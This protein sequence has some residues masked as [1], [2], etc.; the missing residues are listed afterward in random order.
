MKKQYLFLFCVFSLL[1]PSSIFAFTVDA[2]EDKDVFVGATTVLGGSP[3]A[4]G[5]KEPYSYIWIDNNGM[6]ISNE[7]NPL[8]EVTFEGV[9]D[10]FVEVTDGSG[11][12]GCDGDQH[13]MITGISNPYNLS[14]L[15]LTFEGSTTVV[16]DDDNVDYTAPHFEITQLAEENKMYPVCYVSGEL[17]M[18]SGKINYS[19]DSGESLPSLLIRGENGFLPGNN[20]NFTFDV[21]G[22]FTVE[23]DYIEF[24]S[25]T[26]NFSL[27]A[28]LVDYA[29]PF[30]INWQISTDD[31]NTWTSVGSSCNQLYVTHKVPNSNLAFSHFSRP[32]R[33]SLLHIGCKS[34]VGKTTKMEV[35]ESIFN[36][37]KNRVVIKADNET[38]L[39]YYWNYFCSA[40]NTQTILH[41][42]NVKTGPSNFQYADG[43]C[44]AFSI[45]FI[46]LLKMQGIHNAGNHVWYYPIDLGLDNV[47]NF[48]IKKWEFPSLNGTEYLKNGINYTH[49]NV[50]KAG[51]GQAGNIGPTFHNANN[52]NQ[53]FEW[54]VEE[55]VDLDGIPGQS[56][57]NPKSFF[58]NHQ[59]ARIIISDDPE[60]NDPNPPDPTY[61]YYDPSYGVSFEYSDNPDLVLQT[62]QNDV[63]AGFSYHRYI[64]VNESDPDINFD[65][66]SNNIP[67]EVDVPC[68]LIHMRKISTSEPLSIYFSDPMN[69]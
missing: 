48:L 40:F 19:L 4:S 38:Q 47:N 50:L 15:E 2:G 28:N 46:D 57:S 60:P 64:L 67:D 10:Y 32:I 18:V 7:A 54:I 20:F 6:V 12:V 51:I 22:N 3:V 29:D 56:N 1:L 53:Q 36:V 49:R 21:G 45:L 11:F 25:I 35:V 58:E 13:I 69:Q 23:T 55:V 16:N 44:G 52:I 9:M 63:I 59:I 33:H 27:L 8:I 42:S 62:I 31:G 39:T 41:S 65:C 5:G 34:G 37:F 14:I 26:A 66:N 17:L 43:Q 30:E 68:S 24:N 61:K